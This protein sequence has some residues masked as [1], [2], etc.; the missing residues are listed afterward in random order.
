MELS[1]EEINIFISEIQNNSKYDFSEYSIKSFTRRVEKILMDSGL[2]FAELIEKISSDKEFLEQVV[3]DITVN[4]TEIF[5]DPEI[6]QIIRSEIIPLYKDLPE[7]NIWHAGCS[8]G[9]ETFSMLIFMKE[10]GLFDKTNSF[11][12]D[13]NTEVMD[14]AKSGKYKYREIDEYIKNFNTAFEPT[15][16]VDISKYLDI[17]KN[18]SLIK[19]SNELIEKPVFKQYDLTQLSN[20]FEKKYH[21]IFCRN[22]LIY[23]THSLQ[24][25]IFEFFHQNLEPGGTLI[26]GRHEGILGKISDKFEKRGTIYVKR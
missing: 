20:P 3:K 24:N 12:S 8:T 25:R 22:V 15:K 13:L 4:T 21:I 18:K 9:Q 14:V 17:S 23:F 7:I 6:W 5:R 26:I 11:A 1:P 2:Q 19:V 16:N 10:S